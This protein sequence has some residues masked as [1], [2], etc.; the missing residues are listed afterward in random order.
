VYACEIRKVMC[1]AVRMACVN[2]DRNKKA[3][4]QVDRKIRKACVPYGNKAGEPVDMCQADIEHF[5][6]VLGGY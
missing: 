2:V 5:L 4:D 6:S 1:Q 3:C